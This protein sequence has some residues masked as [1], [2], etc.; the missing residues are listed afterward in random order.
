MNWIPAA[1]GMT[2]TFSGL[3]KSA[4]MLGAQEARREAYILYVERRGLQ[5]NNADGR[6]VKPSAFSGKEC[7]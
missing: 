4:E 6:I 1:A 3:F 7:I 2:I 5:R